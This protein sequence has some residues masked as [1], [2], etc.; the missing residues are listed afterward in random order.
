MRLVAR[1]WPWPA[2]DDRHDHLGRVYGRCGQDDRTVREQTNHR[3]LLVR[4]AGGVVRHGGRGQHQEQKHEFNHLFL[5]LM[6]SFDNT[7]L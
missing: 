3:H 7:L 5:L 4:G 1:P 2:V 6:I